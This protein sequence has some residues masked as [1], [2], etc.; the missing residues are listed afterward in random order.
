M[1]GI[2]CTT[3]SDEKGK[4]V[5]NYR[6]GKIYSGRRLMRSQLNSIS[7]RSRHRGEPGGQ[8][9]SHCKKDKR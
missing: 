2:W 7:R 3:A 1:H 8:R 9:T 6:T 5:K 4:G